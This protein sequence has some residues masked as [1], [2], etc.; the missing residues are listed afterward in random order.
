MD[1]EERLEVGSLPLCR[2]I[3]FLAQEA[4]LIVGRGLD[5]QEVHANAV[6]LRDLDADADILIA[7]E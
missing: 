2:G 5:S 7:G 6:G 1:C 3:G 4:R